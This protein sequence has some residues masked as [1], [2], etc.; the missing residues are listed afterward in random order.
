[1]GDN[2][3]FYRTNGKQREGRSDPFY[4]SGA[5][6]HLSTYKRLI[7][8]AEGKALIFLF[9]MLWPPLW[10]FAWLS[11]ID[12]VKSTILFIVTLVAGMIRFYFWMIRSRQNKRLKDLDIK[13][14][15]LDE[16]ERRYNVNNHLHETND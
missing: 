6:L 15:E 13:M 11:N 16:I 9:N 12:N 3:L 7:K 5:D 10:V 4:S 14:R 8:M 1:M 2:K